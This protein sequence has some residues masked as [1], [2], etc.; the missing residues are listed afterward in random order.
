MSELR[1]YLSLFIR[2]LPA[3]LLVAA[4]VAAISVVVAVS[5]PPAYESRTRLIVESPQIPDALAPSTVRLPGKERLQI[6]ENR[7]L[8]RPNMLDIARRLNVLAYQED[9][10]PDE[11]VEAMESRTVINSSA[12]RNEATIMEI[13]FEARTAKLAAQVLNE[14]LQLIQQS[15]VSFRQGRAG[16]TLDFFEIEVE[17]LAKEL[18]DQGARILEFKNAN[19]DSQPNSLEFRQSQRAALQERLEA[20]ERE[21]F[22][23]RSQ[24]QQ[25]IMI[26]NEAKNSGR[27]VVPLT[28]V[29]EKLA[30]AQAELDSALLL[31]SETNPRVKVIKARIVQ[32]EQAVETERQKTKNSDTP[33]ETSNPALNLRLAEI[34]TRVETLEAQKTSTEVKINALTDTIDRTPATTARLEDLQ[35]EYENIQQQYNAAVQRLADA[36]TGE[37]IEVL[38]R[39]ERISIIEQPAIPSEPTKPNR[40]LIA[41]GGIF[42]GI[43]LGLALVV[44]LEVLNRAPRRPEDIIG[45]LGVWPMAAIPYTRS[46]RELFVQRGRKLL[47]IMVILVGVPVAVWSIHEYYLPLDLLADKAMNKLG[48][49]W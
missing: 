27:G 31:Y 10:S 36:S 46:R 7:L 45:K 32:L 43:V 33:K 34:D 47:I 24:R 42:L 11:I 44:S 1:F 26:F 30:E 3:F 16:Q 21:V 18:Q 17:R 2:R 15:D 40:I 49:R 41:G 6:I 38:S 12:R 22:Q 9:M 48:V 23:L 20:A 14:Y 4:I 37:R 13:V 35:R 28:P 39:G 5:L 29:Q 25:M 8:T 19:S